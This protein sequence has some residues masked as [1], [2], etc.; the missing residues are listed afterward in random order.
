MAKVKSEINF[1]EEKVEDVMKKIGQRMR[2]LRIAKGHSSH[3]T[4]AYENDLNRAQY[5]RYERG[6]DLRMT[7]FIKVL[8]ALEISPEDFFSNGVY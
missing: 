6:E 5:S 2:A 8:Q 1:K 3:E 7:T 4:F